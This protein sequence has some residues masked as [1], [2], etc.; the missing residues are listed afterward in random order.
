MV[1]MSAC[2]CTLFDRRTRAIAAGRAA[3]GHLDAQTLSHRLAKQGMDRISSPPL[4]RMIQAGQ[5]TGQR[6]GLDIQVEPWTAQLA[7]F[8]VTN[9]DGDQGMAWDYPAETIRTDPDLS[10]SPPAQ[11]CMSS[12][13]QIK[14]Q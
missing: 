8:A 10:P 4:G 7:A 11:P 5:Y 2:N 6:L 12:R 9:V 3:A 13:H 1:M 14:D